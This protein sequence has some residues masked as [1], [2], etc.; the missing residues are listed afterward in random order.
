MKLRLSDQPVQFKELTEAEQFAYSHMLGLKRSG[1][2][3]VL[4]PDLDKWTAFM[5]KGLLGLKAEIVGA[6]ISLI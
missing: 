3:Y 2:L 6:K 4:K 5:S 1:I